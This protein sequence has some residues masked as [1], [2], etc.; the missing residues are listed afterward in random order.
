MKNECSSMLF[1]QSAK[2]FEYAEWFP[3]KWTKLYIL[4]TSAGHPD[5]LKAIKWGSHTFI[6]RNGTHSTC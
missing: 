4:Q 2:A 5:E 1:T 3:C 6:S